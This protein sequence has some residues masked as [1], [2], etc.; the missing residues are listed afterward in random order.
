MLIFK[1]ITVASH[2][3]SH[4]CPQKCPFFFHLMIC[5]TL[6]QG[7]QAELCWQTQII[8]ILRFSSSKVALNQIFLFACLCETTLTTQKDIIFNKRQQ[9]VIF[10]LLLESDDE[11]G[12]RFSAE[13]SVFLV[14]I[15][16]YTFLSTGGHTTLTNT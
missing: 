1:S 13:E 4:F 5:K 11:I 9:P 15:L 16:Q 8:H 6:V 10:F 3:I 7:F 14:K 12:T 2:A